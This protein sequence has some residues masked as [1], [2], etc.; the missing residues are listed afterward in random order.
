MII[1]GAKL[2]P[3][4]QGGLWWPD[5]RMLVVAD[6]HLEKGSAFAAR[7][8]MLPPYDTRETLN[9]LG[10]LISNYDPALLLCLGDSFHDGD[11]GERLDGEDIRALHTLMDGREWIWLA[12]NHDPEPPDW[13]GGRVVS[14][15]AMAPLIF[16]H[17]PSP[18]PIAGEVAGH[19]HP[20]AAVNIN[21]RR[22]T[23]RCFVE[24]GLRLVLPA[25]GAFTGG[26]DVLDPVFATVFSGPFTVHMLGDGQCHRFAGRRLTPIGRQSARSSGTSEKFK[27]A[28][29]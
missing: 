10:Q 21:G 2:F 29:I 20:K 9:R 14:E 8:Q 15:L 27:I 1:N 12:G 25:F 13:L 3:D 24:D 16:R 28:E 18:G 11:A 7:G 26:L 5:A 23:R 4:P 6:M 17:A 19:L 22:L